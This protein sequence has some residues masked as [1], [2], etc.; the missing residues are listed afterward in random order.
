MAYLTLCRFCFTCDKSQVPP[1]CDWFVLSLVL[2]NPEEFDNNQTITKWSPHKILADFAT[3][4]S[5][6]NSDTPLLHTSVLLM[7]IYDILI[8]H[9]SC[10][11]FHNYMHC[12]TKPPLSNIYNK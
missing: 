9:L 5:L 7:E 8:Y 12:K 3:N 10:L 11:P 6:R 1:D 2:S 4:L